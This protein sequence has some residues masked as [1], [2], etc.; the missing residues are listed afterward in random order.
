MGPKS[1]YILYIGKTKFITPVPLRRRSTVSQA[2]VLI[3]AHL[4]SLGRLGNQMFQVAATIGIAERHNLS[5]RFPTTISTSPIGRLMNLT[6]DFDLLNTPFTQI[7][8]G[9]QIFHEISIPSEGNVRALSL[10]GYYQSPLYFAHSHKTLSQVLRI[11]EN[12]IRRVAEEVP[13]V[14][15]QNSVTVH[16]RRGD[17]SRPPFNQ[18]Y[19]LMD[20]D[21]FLKALEYLEDV[22]LLILLTDDKA[23]CKENLER[24]LPYK[25]IYSPFRDELFDFVLL[26]LGRRLI[27]SNSSFSWWAA[28]LKLLQGDTHVTVIAPSRWY[29]ASGKLAYLDNRV[30]FFPPSWRL[31][32]T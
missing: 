3:F 29:R 6:G 7:A 16:V 23:W 30:H 18:M 15:R 24:R 26:H 8:E 31:I 5:W 17:Y 13:Q 28:F 4:G 11:D 32:E 12:I 22:E 14:L 2:Q 1:N 19:K 20:L 25:V 9:S 10:H 27:L 21:Y